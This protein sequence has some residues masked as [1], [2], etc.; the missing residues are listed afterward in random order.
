MNRTESTLSARD[1]LALLKVRAHTLA[2]QVKKQK[3]DS[4][5]I[6][7]AGFLEDLIQALHDFQVSDG[8]AHKRLATYLRE[9]S[10]CEVCPCAIKCD[11]DRELILLRVC[12]KEKDLNKCVQKR[13]AVFQGRR[14][15][16]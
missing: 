6:A 12:P 9:T 11:L 3:R 8:V 5:D 14:T 4:L 7:V 10:L 1:Q 16:G 13:L 15:D 2:D